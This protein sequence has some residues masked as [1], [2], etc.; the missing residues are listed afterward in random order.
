MCLGRSRAARPC[1]L[2]I[3]NSHRLACAHS[4]S[5]QQA[6]TSLRLSSCL[7]SSTHCFASFTSS[8]NKS[9]VVPL[10]ML[11]W[12]ASYAVGGFL[13]GVPANI[14]EQRVLMLVCASL[15]L[16]VVLLRWK[17]ATPA[18]ATAERQP[19]AQG[20][21]GPSASAQL[22]QAGL[23]TA[24]Q[25]PRTCT[26]EQPTGAIIVCVLPQPQAHAQN[27]HKAS[28]CEQRADHER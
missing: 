27:E 10:A 26:E 6:L 28:E 1:N 17:N 18:A 13:G 3:H 14:G 5:L 11:V 21:P 7:L 8:A 12:S 9:Q 24:T 2:A 23:A 25:E 22:E 19:E 16:P 15:M 20:Q 4:A